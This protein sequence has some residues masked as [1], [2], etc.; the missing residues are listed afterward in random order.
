MADRLSRAVMGFMQESSDQLLKE[1]IHKMLDCSH[2]ETEIPAI[3]CMAEDVSILLRD[4]SKRLDGQLKQAAELG[5]LWGK[6]EHLDM[7]SAIHESIL[8][9]VLGSMSG[10]AITQLFIVGLETMI[11]DEEKCAENA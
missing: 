1:V 3:S 10:L 11:R 4:I 2:C 8:I 7:V 5:D 6:K 9:A